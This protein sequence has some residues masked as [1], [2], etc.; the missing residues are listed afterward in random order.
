MA[1]VPAVTEITSRVATWDAAGIIDA[2][3]DHIFNDTTHLAIDDYNVGQGLT[4]G[5]LGAGL[6]Y[7]V[8]L[9]KSASG[10]DFIKPS[11]EPSGSIT[12]A[13]NDTPTAPTGT[14]ADWS[15]ERLGTDVT[16]GSP[17]AGSK[18]WVVELED[19][20]FLLITNTANTFHTYGLHAGRIYVSFLSSDAATAGQDGLGLLSGQPYYLGSSADDWFGTAVDDGTLHWAT[21][22]WADHA[23]VA[24]NPATAD[25]PA[26]AFVTYRPLA[27]IIAKCIDI[28]GTS[29]D[30]IIGPYKYLKFSDL[31]QVP[32][33]IVAD[34]ASN[35]GWMHINK[36][37]TITPAPKIIWDK[38]V[39]P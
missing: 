6:N 23:I 12:D 19:A 39:T 15:G 22:E 18:V 26:P 27:P 16:V 8:N 37:A 32:K 34:G 2:F 38:T 7:Q 11:I 13:G 5:F 9:R 20:F 17:G 10:N 33:T 31:S 14:S 21:N 1:L 3:R 25:S 29:A 4:V 36:T 24:L 30:G 28:E 35:Q